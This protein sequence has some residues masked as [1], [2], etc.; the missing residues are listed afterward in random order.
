MTKKK[1][2]ILGSTGSI[3]VNAL[4]VASAFP[5]R[6]EVVALSAWGNAALL[7][8][9]AWKFKP[10]ILCIKDED[11]AAALGNSFGKK[12]R[13]KVYA[14]TQGLVRLIRETGAELVLVAVVGSAGLVPVL[15]SLKRGKNV[16]L[17]NKE[18]IVAA[19]E[20]VM[21]LARA[22]GVRILPVDSEHSAIFQCLN[23]EPQAGVRRLILTA[24]GG[25]FRELSRKEL[26]KVTVED[27]LAH[28]TW[29]MGNKVTVDSATL[30]NK[31][32]EVIEAHHLFNMPAEKI[33]VLVHPQSIVHS[34]VEF[35][36][37]SV[38][39][40]LGITDMKL[41]IQYALSWPERMSNN[42]PRLNLASCGPLTFSRPDVS[43]F[44]CLGFAYLALKCGGTMPAV[45]AGSAEAA[46]E[47][48]LSK[49][50]GFTDIPRIIKKVMAAHETIKN[51]KLTE[52]LSA[53]AWARSTALK[54]TENVR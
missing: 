50:A 5:A 29:D 8:E 36:D 3:G 26:E 53:E 6:F 54:E 18:S 38:L 48:F 43:R 4:K 45:L 34:L 27:A 1:I 13:P 33:D 7:K 10:S 21:K 15:E 31:G 28:P 52:I 46:V 47:A 30:M 22:K 32:F 42:L 41:P 23:G 20:Y 2:A 24:S 37:G 25:P 51:P 9:Q 49:A 40:Q 39:A 16:A 44:E 35:A 12:Y 11:R 17:A 19:G 14:G